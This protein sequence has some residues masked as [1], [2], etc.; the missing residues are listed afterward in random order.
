MTSKTVLGL[1]LIALG[2]LAFAYQ[3]ISYTTRDRQLDLGPVS[4]T[5]ERTHRIPLPPV[6]G[7]FA[8]VGG[9]VLL[10]ADKKGFG[11]VATR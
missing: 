3:G 6:L 10:V 7:A 4:V 1:V 8:L 2:V 9:V 11:R 5:T